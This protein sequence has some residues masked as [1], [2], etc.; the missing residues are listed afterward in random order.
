MKN[1]LIISPS[2][3]G[4]IALCTLNLFESLKKIQ[5]V[6]VE[7]LLLYKEANGLKG[8]ENC[9]YIV[10]KTTPNNQT[11]SYFNKIK[12]IRNE[13]KQFN[14]DITISTLIIVNVLN[15]L[16][17]GKEKKIGIFHSPFKQSWLL[18]FSNVIL[19]FFSYLC[20]FPFLD[21]LF[22]VS[23][24]V[25]NSVLHFPTIN[26]K[27]VKVVYNIHNLE[28]IIEMSNEELGSDLSYF[29]KPTILYCGRLDD[30]KAPLR[31]IKAFEK[32]NF[33]Q[34]GNLI[35]IGDDTCNLQNE[36]LNYITTHNLAS[37]VFYLGPKSNP[38]KYMKASVGLISS[39]YS[40][41]LPGVMIESLALHKPVITTNSSEGIWEI[42]EVHDKYENN[43]RNLMETPSGYISSN[44]SY[45]NHKY[46][47]FDIENLSLAIDA[48]INHYSYVNSNF[49]EKVTAK[50]VLNIYLN[51]AQNK[52]II[53]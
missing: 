39:S 43:L 22:C 31:A 26:R 52:E 51:Y 36:L 17:G 16:A 29:N 46:E 11:K 14:P 53:I 20:L 1:I 45:H 30:N 50:N 25:K 6:N 40:E 3:A 48:T 15:I 10:D 42:M 2:N 44:L 12:S 32:S 35:L 41:G 8:F 49:L 37:S 5:N 4:T 33:S 47:I 13:K 9:K 23:E 18:G 24:E 38:Y 34:N 28:K 19:Q 7:C 21:N 27:K